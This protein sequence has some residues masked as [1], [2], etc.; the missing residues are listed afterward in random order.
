MQRFDC[1]EQGEVK[2]YAGCKIEHNKSE[3]SIKFTQP[4]II[5]SFEDQFET[6]EE[7]R[8]VT[9]AE[10][11]TVLVPTNEGEGVGPKLHK[12]YRSGVGKLLHMMRWSRPEIYNSVRDLPKQCKSPNAHVKAMHR[13]MNYCKSTPERG[14][15]LKPSRK[16]DGKDK[17]F[18]FRINAK[19]DAAY[20]KCPVTKRSVTGY[21]V[22]LEGAPIAVKGAMQR[23]VA[24][25]VTEAES[26]AAVACAQEMLYAMY[27][28]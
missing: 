20:S 21:V 19:S 9:P 7:K 2:E 23:I 24:L 10:P 25:S 28:L 12:Y 27:V 13:I 15:F 6:N 11:G 14:W 26:I 1:T 22:K 4:I 5:Q 18:K 17:S 3:G 8:R 16:W